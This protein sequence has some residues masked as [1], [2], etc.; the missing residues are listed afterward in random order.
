MLASGLVNYL[1]R[2]SAAFGSKFVA[3]VIFTYGVNQ[4]MGESFVFG[5]RSFY[6]LDVVGMSSATYG[7]LAG[8]SHIPW[9]LKSLFGLLSD[10][11]PI[12]GRH[13]SPY[14]LL[15]GLLGATAT[16]LLVSLPACAM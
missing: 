8:A 4:G 1:S 6:L 10:T 13:R 5:A 12:N 2:L 3:A 7:Q 14:M 11:V 15:A 16:L 9:Q